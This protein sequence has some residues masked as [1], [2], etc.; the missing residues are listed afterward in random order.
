[1]V[2]LPASSSSWIFSGVM[3][4]IFALECTP[5]VTIPAWAPVIDAAGMSIDWSAMAS[6]A[7]VVCSPVESSTSISRSLGTGIRLLAMSMRLSVTPF[8]ADTTTTT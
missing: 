5:S 1:M 2:T 3:L 6:S 7:I 4:R 8:I